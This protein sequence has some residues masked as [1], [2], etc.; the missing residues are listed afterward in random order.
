MKH[1]PSQHLA[2]VHAPPQ[3]SSARLLPGG[4][5]TPRGPGT[6][7]I[8]QNRLNQPQPLPP[9]QQKLGVNKRGEKPGASGAIPSKRQ[10][11]AV[12]NL[13]DV[14][15][16]ASTQAQFQSSTMNLPPRNSQ[17]NPGMNQASTAQQGS[18]NQNPESQ[19]S[20]VQKIMK[21]LCCGR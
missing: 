8:P 2:A 14:T 13:N 15:P 4:A 19:P 6:P 21:A 17:I 16:A 20:A 12:G 5:D 3:N 7:G 1:H 9:A 10:S 18:R 11:G